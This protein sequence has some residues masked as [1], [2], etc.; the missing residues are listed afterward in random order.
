[1]ISVGMIYGL[2]V[3]NVG[4]HGIETTQDLQNRMA[5]DYGQ[6]G[7]RE[8]FQLNDTDPDGAK[9]ILNASSG[10]IQ[11]EKGR[12]T[13]GFPELGLRETFQLNDT[14]P[15][16][17]KTILNASSGIIQDEKGRATAGFPEPRP[18]G[19]QNPWDLRRVIAVSVY[20]DD[21]K[22]YERLTVIAGDVK[23]LFGRD[24]VLRVY[25]DKIKQVPGDLDAQVVDMT[26]TT[27]V[28]AN[29]DGKVPAN[30]MCWRFFPM[31]D[32]TVDVF[33]SRDTDN[34]L[35]ERDR[36]AVFEWLESTSLECHTMRDNMGHDVPLLGGM[37]GYRGQPEGKLL[38]QLK[39][40]IYT[41]A[42]QKGADQEALAAH[43]WPHLKCL[44][45]DAY[46]CGS[47][48][49]NDAKWLPFPSKREDGQGN[50][51]VAT[52]VGVPP[53]CPGCPIDPGQ[54]C[55]EKCRKKPEWV[56]C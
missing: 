42:T 54:V 7:L 52:G 1:M 5:G 30:K 56:T 49:F 32:P 47:P 48:K 13:A 36:D 27:W 11:D 25:S 43:L 2:R 31:L 38:E 14:D 28:N 53:P 45:H 23:R 51:P 22:Y 16:G 44:A 29:I 37:W 34:A 19:R 10:I 17:A 39:T 26:N 15:D 41:P 4:L 50:P 8:T 24:W 21:A 18:Q 35:I 20:G 46:H 55:P 6:L 3:C 33:L 12:V 40:T 9:T